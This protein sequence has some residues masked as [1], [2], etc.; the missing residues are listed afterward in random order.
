MFLKKLVKVS[1]Q[2]R[3]T[4]RTSE[5]AVTVVVQ[6]GNENLSM[7]SQIQFLHGCLRNHMMQRLPLFSWV[8]VHKNPELTLTESGT[9]VEKE[10]PTKKDNWDAILYSDKYFTEGVHLYEFIYENPNNLRTTHNEFLIGCQQKNNG[11]PTDY[12]TGTLIGN[13]AWTRGVTLVEQ[14]TVHNQQGAIWQD[15][16]VG[17]LVLDFPKNQ[18]KFYNNGKLVGHNDRYE[19]PSRYA[20]CYFALF[21]SVDVRIRHTRKYTVAEL[22][23][24]NENNTD[25]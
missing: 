22:E 24:R 10:S 14:P 3:T 1:E 12:F 2:H 19:K 17:S 8:N 16:D 13:W 15:G 18:L 25:K 5:V 7:A 11:H 21:L 6:H 20:K 23:R 9:I 4:M